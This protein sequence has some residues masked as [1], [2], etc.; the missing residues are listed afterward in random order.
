MQIATDTMAIRVVVFKDDGQW[1]AQ[2]LEFDIGAQ[3]DN[4]DLLND[5]LKV[6][7]MAE[8]K[9]SMER[10]SQPFAGID[11]APERFHVMWKHRARSVEVSAAPAPWMIGQNKPA[12]L[13]FG[14]VA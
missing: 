8:F 3:A 7:L 4:I 2:C 14:L 6:V 12:H 11:P 9:E 10:H 1:V 5:R 13:D